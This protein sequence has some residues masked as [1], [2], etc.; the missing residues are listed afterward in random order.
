MT[1][2]WRW[3]G[4]GDPISLEEIRQAGVTDVVTSLY[5]QP[6]GA[7]WPMGAIRAV[8]KAVKAAG[9]TWSVVESVPVHEAIKK[10]TGDFERYVEVYK[11]NLRRLAR[12]G[13]R[14]V[15]TNFMPVHDWARTDLHLVLPDGSVSLGYDR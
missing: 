10:R 15:C 2:G 5:T 7:C 6:V 1:C 14:T 3:F 12:C 13:I 4:E 8:A 11:T 9:M